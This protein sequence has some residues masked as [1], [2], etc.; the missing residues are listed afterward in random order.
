MRFWP[1]LISIS[2]AVCVPC[3]I[4]QR[5]S[6]KFYSGSVGFLMRTSI[7]YYLGGPGRTSGPFFSPPSFLTSILSS[8]IEWDTIQNAASGMIA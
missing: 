2:I 8:S 6:I 1:C 7:H 5:R 3:S 4:L